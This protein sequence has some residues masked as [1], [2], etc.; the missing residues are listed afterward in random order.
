M[1]SKN[2]NTGPPRCPYCGGTTV[3]RGTE[4]IYLESREPG[5]L[6]VC[7]NYPRCDA[8]VRVQ[9]GTLKPLGTMADGK[10]RALRRDAHKE[11][12]K[13]HKFGYMTRDE[14]YLWLASQLLIPRNE[15]HI[16]M[17]GEYNCRR[18][19]EVCQKELVAR[20]KAL[21]ACRS[22]NLAKGAAAS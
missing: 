12:D 3:L 21:N 18:V 4:E 19:I 1:K 6:Y 17:M 15:A 8:Y 13:L 14:A 11:F 10:L 7:K 9:K 5:K 20:S 22:T 16:A 2:K